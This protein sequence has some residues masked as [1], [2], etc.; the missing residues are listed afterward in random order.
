MNNIIMQ[1]RKTA[2]HP[3]LMRALYTDER[4]AEMAK[5]LLANGAAEP[6]DQRFVGITHAQLVGVLQAW[7]DYELHT[8]CC[9]KVRVLGARALP[10]SAFFEA[11]KVQRLCELVAAQQ[12]QQPHHKV[13]V[14]SQ[15]T[16]ILDILEVALVPVVNRRTTVSSEAT[17]TVDSTEAF[18]EK[19]ANSRSTPSTLPP[20]P[21]SSSS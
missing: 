14:F 8:L 1:L 17:S 10:D 21:S 11:G 18:T 5:V 16:R 2:N 12:Q 4:V 20:P 9:E 3:L 19:S 13:L 7:S 15:M 6:D